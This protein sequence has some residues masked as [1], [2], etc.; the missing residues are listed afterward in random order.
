MLRPRRDPGQPDQR[1]EGVTARFAGTEPW[2]LL[3]LIGAHHSKIAPLVDPLDRARSIL[4]FRVPLVG[5]RRFFRRAEARVYL[6]LGF[7]VLDPKTQ[8]ATPL[9]LPREWPRAAPLLSY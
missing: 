2:G 4:E 3:R 9:I 1:V 5:G 8:A 7:R 6:A